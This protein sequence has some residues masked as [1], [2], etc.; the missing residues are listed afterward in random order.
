MRSPLVL[1]VMA[2]AFAAGCFPG[3]S[4]SQVPGGGNGACARCGHGNGG[5]GSAGNGGSGS[6]GNSGSGS[7]GAA[8]S[9]G[10][11]GS[12][13]PSGSGSGSS[14]GGS[15]GAVCEAYVI[16]DGGLDQPFDCTGPFFYGD[17]GSCPED[18]FGTNIIDYNDCQRA[19]GVAFDLLDANGVPTNHSMTSDPVTG[20]VLLCLPASPPLTYT[21]SVSGPGYETFYYGE[22]Q[23]ELAFDLPAIG[24]LKQS[25]LTLLESF[26]ND[27]LDLTKAAAVFFVYGLNGQCGRL[28]QGTGWTV[29]L[30]Y[31]D[32][33]GLY[34]DGSYDV[35]YLNGIQSFGTSTTSY[36]VALV[37]N[38]DVS[39]GTFVVPVYSNPDAGGCSVQNAALGFTGRLYVAPGDYSEQGIFLE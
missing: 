3:Q 26:F 32:G 28:G 30:A 9:A 2:L 29:Q 12:G 23:G 33:G 16:P 6:A 14:S 20:S 36:G 1:A 34:P 19:C 8:S 22:M 37:A 39:T 17:G 5:S 35:F 27:Q 4:N 7:A 11:S 31:P 13:S 15:T 24:I 10:S 38:I 21:P 18:W 25:E